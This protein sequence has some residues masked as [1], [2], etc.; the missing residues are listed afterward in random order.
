MLKRLSVRDFGLVSALDLEPGIG[1]TALTGETGAGKSMMVAA[2]GF[3]LGG[4]ARR[5]WVRA[6][7]ARTTVSAIFRPR[8][9]HPVW[10]LC[11]ELGHDSRPDQPLVF[12]RTLMREG[13]GRA[14]LN[15]RPVSLAQ[16]GAIGAL[17]VDIHGQNENRG[18]L[19]GSEHLR[20][21]D[22]FGGHDQQRKAVETEWAAW[23]AA[24]AELDDVARLAVVSAEEA[25]YLRSCSLELERLKPVPGEEGYLSSERA[26][27]QALERS[28][29]A[30][31]DAL[32]ALESARIDTTLSHI[33]RL[34]QRGR[35]R[36]ETGSEDQG[37]ASLIGSAAD[38]LEKA[39]IEVD[40]VRRA[41]EMASSQG[42][43]GP[44]A[45]DQVE[46]RLFALRGAARRFGVAPDQLSDFREALEARL[47]RLVHVED[48]R[49]VKRKAEAAA[50]ERFDRAADVLS[51]ARRDAA[52]RLTS[53]VMSELSPLKLGSMRFRVNVVMRADG[54][55]SDTGRDE[56]R[57]E[58]SSAHGAD[59]A[60]LSRIASGGELARLS[61][62][63]SVC[64]SRSS[65]CETLVFDEADVGVGGS[66]AAAIGERLARL[67]GDRQV[68]AITHS[69][70][71]AA[72]AS[73]QWRIC[74]LD[75]PD[76]TETRVDILNRA[77]RREEIARMLAGESVT[78]EA[79]A[80]AGRLLL[81]A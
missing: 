70:Q 17:L 7:C 43:G 19:Q 59:F 49:I 35:V 46:A 72:A 52:I 18:L 63:L 28:A 76:G 12:T 24:C 10:I 4:R 54:E 75:R 61:L 2:L 33:T 45:V 23:R 32:G 41:L 8:R 73:G 55:G 57:F 42:G 29:I 9:N 15:E 13:G 77:A 1:F 38:G 22:E 47:E 39:M 71:V 36:T 66:V 50:R 11:A 51:S 64:L 62:A 16:L 80:A 58:I 20:L 14:F 44:E 48:E 65:L 5:E 6:G 68:L 79:R 78:R 40:E 69:P 27:L 53:A 60:P 30:V 26:R 21:L 31:R 3:V 74:R 34:L 67:G 81:R 56:V 25:S 37:M